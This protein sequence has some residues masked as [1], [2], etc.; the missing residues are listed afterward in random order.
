MDAD[1]IPL[2]RPCPFSFCD[3]KLDD[4]GTCGTCGKQ[5]VDLSA[6]TEEE[7]EAFLERGARA[8]VAYLIDV[9][10]R[11]LFGRPALTAGL[12]FTAGAAATL[13][14]S[15]VPVSACPDATV[16]DAAPPNH[17]LRAMEEA[18]VRFAVEEPEPRRAPHRVRAARRMGKIA[19]PPKRKR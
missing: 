10:G 8:C 12:A 7:A 17:I 13:A 2:S 19:R 6:G 16:V 5:V 14:P 18:R 4:R 1:R 11:V 9:S 3:L 15:P